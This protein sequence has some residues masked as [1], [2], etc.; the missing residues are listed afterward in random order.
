MMMIY[1]FKYKI[2][3]ENRELRMQISSRRV[4]LILNWLM[5]GQ[6][7]TVT[8]IHDRIQRRGWPVGRRQIQRDLAIIQDEISIVE[9]EKFIGMFFIS[10][11]VI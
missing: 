4:V 3:I 2:R 7:L 8:E 6:R 5:C 9:S 11:H 10:S 1:R